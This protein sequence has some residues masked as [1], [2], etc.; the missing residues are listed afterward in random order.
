MFGGWQCVVSEKRVYG[1]TF[2]VLV[3]VPGCACLEQPPLIGLFW[4]TVIVLILI[5]LKIVTELARLNGAKM[6]FK[7]VR[8]FQ[9]VGLWF[10]E[11]LNHL[12]WKKPFKIIKPNY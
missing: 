8:I 11:P 7:S 2:T 10:I 6:F 1:H 5:H 4:L 12:G 9:L 3:R